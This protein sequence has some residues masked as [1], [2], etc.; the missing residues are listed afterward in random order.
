MS[1]QSSLVMRARVIGTLTPV[2]ATADS[3]FFEQQAYSVINVT[4]RDFT[5]I[6]PLKAETQFGRRYCFE[7]D[8][9]H[10]YFDIDQIEVVTAAATGLAAP[11]VEQYVDSAG[12][13][14]IQSPRYI[15]TN[16]QL[17]SVQVPW[18]WHRLKD[19]LGMH[20]TEEQY[21]N[22]VKLNYLADQSV[23][24]LRGVCFIYSNNS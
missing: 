4:T 7:R 11:Q 22:A 2:L 6:T 18:E 24:F 9:D 21:T 13:L 16:Q 20:I 14:L 8:K 1:S 10:D 5:V 19:I 15:F 17:N 23:A 3:N 12:Y